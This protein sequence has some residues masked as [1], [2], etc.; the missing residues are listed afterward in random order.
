[1]LELRDALALEEPEDPHDGSRAHPH[2]EP[3]DAEGGPGVRPQS[4]PHRGSSFEPC[5]A[6]GSAG[7][8]RTMVVDGGRLSLLGQRAVNVPVTTTSTGISSRDSCMSARIFGWSYVTYIRMH[9]WPSFR[10]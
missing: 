6:C 4:P 10:P 7:D 5:R 1:M 8:A 2:P 3:D 9:L